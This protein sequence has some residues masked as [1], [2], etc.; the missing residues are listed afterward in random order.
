MDASSETIAEESRVSDNL[1]FHYAELVA[2]V[3]RRDCNGEMVGDPLRHAEIA[4]RIEL[5][6]GDC[7]K[8]EPSQQQ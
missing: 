5:S 1:G 4:W 8:V 6:A 3:V 2:V 7:N